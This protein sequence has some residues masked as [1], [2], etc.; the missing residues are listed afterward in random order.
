[1]ELLLRNE[2]L[3]AMSAI[4]RSDRGKPRAAELAI[5]LRDLWTTGDD[6]IREDVAVAWALSP[7]FENGGKDALR[8]EIASGHGPGAIAAAGVGLR[9]SAAQP[10]RPHPSAFDDV[11]LPTSASALLARTI[12]EGSRRDRLHA[13]AVA[14]PTGQ[15]L[16]AIRTAAQDEDAD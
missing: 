13:L 11:D 3:R 4:V 10:A 9:P 14:R 16:V 8:V 6:A 2:A 12:V 7:V 15:L 5:R 1:P